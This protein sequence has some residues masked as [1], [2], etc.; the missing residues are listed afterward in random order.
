LWRFDRRLYWDQIRAPRLARQAKADVHHFTGG[1]LPWRCPH[2]VVLTLHDLVWLRGVNLGRPYVRGYF[3]RFQPYLARR[4]DAIV[5]DTHAA[6]ND[7]ADGLHVNPARIVVAGAGV[8]DE[9]FGLP[10]RPS[11]PRFVL[12]VGTV[13]ERKDLVTAVRA[14]ARLPQIGLI[15]VGALTAYAKQ[16]VTTA[17][18]LGVAQ[19][20]EL[21]GYVD[22]KSLLDLFATAAVLVFPSRYEGFGLPPLQAL[23]CGLP[24]VA[25]RIPVTQEV[26]GDCVR[27]FSPGDDVEMARQIEAALADAEA[28]A[29]LVICGRLRARQFKWADV[30]A[31]MVDVYHSVARRL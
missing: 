11:N 4:A 5:A 12:A 16:V 24:V 8:D 3:G 9:Y 23:A 17:R 26:L 15:A 25:S 30:A 27:Y 7:I 13:E 1:T 10:R 28:N 18:D 20:V 6:R 19:R 14:I 31:K 22:D 2:P 29:Q 21:R